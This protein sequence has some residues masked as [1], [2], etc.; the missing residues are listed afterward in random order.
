MKA[1]TFVQGFGIVPGLVIND[2]KGSFVR[3]AFLQMGNVG[4]PESKILC[5]RDYPP[6]CKF[7]KWIDDKYRNITYDVDF[8]GVKLTSKPKKQLMIQESYRENT[9][10]VIFI[11]KE[12]EVAIAENIPKAG[13]IFLEKDLHKLLYIPKWTKEIVLISKDNTQ[14]VFQIPE[15]VFDE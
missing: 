8:Y 13:F 7:T 5:S 6:R 9:D 14:E 1:F 3:E 4:V 15:L 2:P 12:Y 10:I 11:P